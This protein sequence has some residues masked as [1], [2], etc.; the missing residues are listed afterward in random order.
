MKKRIFALLLA[1][2]MV[3]SLSGCFGFKGSVS[4]NSDG[5]GVVTVQSGL[6]QEAIDTLAEMDPDSVDLAGGQPMTI[7]GV[8]YYGSTER[9]SFQNLDEL[10]TVLSAMGSGEVSGLTV[11]QD[12][13]GDFQ[14]SVP[15]MDVDSMEQDMAEA[16][17]DLEVD[18]AEIQQLMEQMMFKLSFA[19]PSPVCQVSGDPTG[20][21][22]SGNTVTIDLLKTTGACGFST[23]PSAVATSAGPFSDVARDAWYCDAVTA[24]S[25]GGLLTGV[26][27]SRFDPAGTVT[28]SQLC[29]MLAK[30]K[31]LP[32]GE[33][34]GYWAGLAIQSCVNAG[35]VSTRGDITP[36][37]YDVPVNREATVCA[38]MR[39]LPDQLRVVVNPSPAIP[40][41]ASV[42]QGNQ[43]T[44]TDAYRYGVAKGDSTGAFLP[45]SLLTRSEVSQLFFNVGWTSPA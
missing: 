22:V 18:P 24:L 10:N 6:T 4:V 25:K 37:N 39:A 13:N 45:A 16:N 12:A 34:N 14:L 43:G 9:H 23:S 32:T 29:Q 28:W 17:A 36:A 8:T 2:L 3:L 20:V 42:T 31:G 15:A 5:S 33:A 7:D 11:T 19:F 41:L 38:M 27:G 30:A 1:G 26:G 40:D 21:T 35:F 44:V